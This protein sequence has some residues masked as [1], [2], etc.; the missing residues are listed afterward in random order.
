MGQVPHP[1]DGA[2][3]TKFNRQTPGGTSVPDDGTAPGAISVEAGQGP[4]IAAEASCSHRKMAELPSV[5]LAARASGPL[6]GPGGADRARFGVVSVRFAAIVHE[7]GLS[8]WH[9]TACGL[10]HSRS[11]FGI[12]LPLTARV[13]RHLGCGCS[14]VVEHDLAKVGVEGSSPFA[15]S[16]FS[17]M[18]NYRIVDRP[19]LGGLV[20]FAP[21]T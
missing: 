21:E 8:A 5:A 7:T 18:A 11:A 9:W 19:P 14:S 2:L 16:R 4:S 1:L 17:S 12:G 20:V 15:R 10:L 3:A 6:R 13:R